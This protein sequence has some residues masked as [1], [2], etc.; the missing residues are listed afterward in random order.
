MVNANFRGYGGDA[1]QTDNYDWWSPVITEPK[2]N[3]LDEYNGTYIFPDGSIFSELNITSNG[4]VLTMT[5]AMGSTNLQNKGG[6]NFYLNEYGAPVIFK[7]DSNNVIDSIYISVQG[8]ELFGKKY[9]YQYVAPIVDTVFGGGYIYNGGNM[10]SGLNDALNA[11]IAADIEKQIGEQIKAQL[12]ADEE[13]RKATAILADAEIKRL[14]AEEADAENKRLSAIEA[15]RIAKEK[16]ALAL[17]AENKRVAAIL[18]ETIAK[19]KAAL[20]LA[21]AER[22]KLA[23]IEAQKVADAKK[24]TPSVIVTPQVEEKKLV[25][26]VITPEQIQAKV[27]VDNLTKNTTITPTKPNNTMLIGGILLAVVVLYVVTKD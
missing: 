11:Q 4:A 21:E 24:L 13:F 23:A 7:R 25:Q 27:I 16:A 3:T 12:L 6:D 9:G 5:S 8:I 15:E 1:S 20:A 10:L 14:A 22:Q 26:Q 19:E 18:A 17:D 2:Y